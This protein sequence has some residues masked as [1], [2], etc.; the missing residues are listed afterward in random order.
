MGP[1]FLSSHQ[2]AT[3]KYGGDPYRGK[4]WSRG[5]A[6]GMETRKKYPSPFSLSYGLLQVEVP[7]SEPSRKVPN[8]EW[9]VTTNVSL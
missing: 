8:A 5:R 2:D 9:I 3:K 6:D 4:P 1:G 7:P